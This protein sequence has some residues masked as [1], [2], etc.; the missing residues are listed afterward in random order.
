M[1][2][3]ASVWLSNLGIKSADFSIFQK[4][5]RIYNTDPLK[6]LRSSRKGWI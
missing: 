4:L 6:G 1:I 2:A 3:T 5:I